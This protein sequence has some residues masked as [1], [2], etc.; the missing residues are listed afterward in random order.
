VGTGRR[1]VGLKPRVVHSY[2]GREGPE[3][4]Q[5]RR[6]AAEHR[7]EER[8]ARRR[9]EA[10]HQEHDASEVAADSVVLLPREA[11]EVLTTHVPRFERRKV[12]MATDLLLY[13]VQLAP[14]LLDQLLGVGQVGLPRGRPVHGA[15]FARASSRVLSALAVASTSVLAAMMKSFRWSPRILW[16]HQVTVTRPHS[17]RRAG[18]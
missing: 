16:V 4:R 3:R 12:R 11:G 18:W 5:R 17:V 6:L 1:L 8:P 14:E 2:R 9:S 10:V 13:G 15:P 7:L